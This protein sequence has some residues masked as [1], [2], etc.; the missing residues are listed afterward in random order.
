MASLSLLESPGEDIAA[1]L[2]DVSLLLST[3]SSVHCP[4]ML[5]LT[6]L[7]ET[8]QQHLEHM[9]PAY[10]PGTPCSAHSPP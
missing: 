1:T 2:K 4:Q 9:N 10:S 3:V 6:F 7:Q 5:S 8:L